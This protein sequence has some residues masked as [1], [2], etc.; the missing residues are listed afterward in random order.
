MGK[1]TILMV[2]FNSYVSH[3][4]RVHSLVP[5]SDLDAPNDLPQ[6][7]QL[8]ESIAQ[9]RLQSR[10]HEAWPL[11]DLD[12]DQER[13]EMDALSQQ[14][15]RLIVFTPLLHL[16]SQDC[17]RKLKKPGSLRLPTCLFQ[18]IFRD[19]PK[20]DGQIWWVWYCKFKWPY[21]GMHHFQTHPCYSMILAFISSFIPPNLFKSPIHI[22][23]LFLY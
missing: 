5:L 22:D 2:I 12:R 19:A 8:A 15:A 10:L 11:D 6:A 3:Y 16:T 21:W 17:W 9:A 4:Q 13:I 20:F 14:F 18:G 23:P 1:S 7:R